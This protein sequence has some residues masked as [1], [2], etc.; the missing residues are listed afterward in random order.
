VLILSKVEVHPICSI[1][2]A[3]TIT[4]A[5]LSGPATIALATSIL[6]A[7]AFAS[8]EQGAP[9]DLRIHGMQLVAVTPDS[10]SGNAPRANTLKKPVQ[11][12]VFEAFSPRVAVRWDERFLYVEGNG[13]PAH[14]MMVGI[15][16]WQQQVPIIQSYTGAN[17]WRIP[18][19]PRPAAR[20]TA[21]KGRFLR[22]AIALAVNGIPIFNPQNNRGELAAEIGEL[23]Q[24]GGHCGRADDY[25]Y[26]VAPLHLQSVAGP[27]RPVAYALDGY[28]IF[29][30]NDPDGS[31]PS[32]LDGFNGH[33]TAAL[34]YHYHASTRY[35]YV[36]GGF[37]G[38]VLERDGQ[39]DPQ[40]RAEP[41]REALP[42]LKG[43][44][45]TGFEALE[46]GAFKLNYRF[47]EEAR[48]ITYAP[49]AEGGYN[50]D[51]QNGKDA[52]LHQ[53]FSPKRGGGPRTAGPPLEERRPEVPNR[54]PQNEGAQPP[55]SVPNPGGFM[56][57]SPE[58]S[59]GGTLPVEYTGDG[60]GSTLPLEW[61]GVPTGTKAFTLLMHHLDPEGKIK[62]YWILY[63]LPETLVS[64]PKNSTGTGVLGSNFQGN[65]GYQPPHSK[66]PGA[67]RYVLSLYA[68]SS[69]LDI[70]VPASKVNYDTILAAMQGKILATS[71]LSVTY[72]RKGSEGEAPPPPPP[73]PR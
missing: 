2:T 58:V 46:K 41:I 45:I 50:F 54:P 1:K 10:K 39:V 20:P 5:A 65:V 14:P 47:N 40:P 23:D 8:N 12:S 28:P 4:S 42:P 59:N 7:T 32:D 11:A 25:H 44:E 22:G 34:G 71:D 69:P 13:L 24:W 15:T 64:L 68:L 19:F 6:C 43:A 53:T 62:W 60:A 35:P 73:R 16:N 29:G 9:S 52:A 70:R 30:L 37:H 17:A 63:N 31:K 56:L 3:A 48:F 51:F 38:E 21:I 27:G 66:G 26:H 18:L 55:L 57:K 49:N 36:N 67:K 72:T 61:S 33:T